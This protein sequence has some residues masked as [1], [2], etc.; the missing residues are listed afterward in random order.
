MKSI[1]ISIHPYIR[2]FFLI[3]VISTIVLLQHIWLL[4]LIYIFFILPLIFLTGSINNHIRL[5]IFGILP[6]SLT[7]ILIY[8]VIMEG[9]SG[10]W[11]FILLR[12][13]KILNATT[14]FQI[15]LTIKSDSLFQ[16]FRMIGFKG[17]KLITLIGTF[18][19]WIDIKRRSEQIITAR[20]ARGFIGKRSY[21]NLTRQFPYIL[22]PLIIG[23]LRTSIERSQTW[24]QWNIVELVNCKKPESQSFPILINL[25]IVLLTTLC[26]I[27]GI[28]YN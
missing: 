19:V 20:F 15:V 21:L 17:E 24:T 11:D 18:T 8:I 22:V 3:G 6:I 28:I 25:V 7:F 13:L 5:L 9:A 1:Y 16:T 4:C 10:G 14:T 2:L 12:I 26:L 27:T 23:I